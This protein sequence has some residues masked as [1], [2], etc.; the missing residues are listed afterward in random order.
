MS[1]HMMLYIGAASVLYFVLL[2]IIAAVV[3]AADCARKAR[4]T[5][6][7]CISA[8]GAAIAAITAFTETAALILR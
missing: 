1:D 7:G 4:D 5:V 3:Y 8:D 2:M 6:I